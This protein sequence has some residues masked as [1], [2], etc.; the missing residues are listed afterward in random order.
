MSIAMQQMK[1]H[2]V[3]LM[4]GFLKIIAV[5]ATPGSVT[6]KRFH[7][8]FEDVFG[9]ANA[10]A[11]SMLLFGLFLWKL[12]A[13]ILENKWHESRVGFW[14]ITIACLLAIIFVSSL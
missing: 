6:F 2:H 13:V 4:A 7:A 14:L 5:M 1:P 9:R 10:V 12:G 3:A 11:L 8:P